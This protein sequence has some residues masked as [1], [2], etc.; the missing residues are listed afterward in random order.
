MNT[1][2]TFEIKFNKLLGP[3][4][5]VGNNFIGFLPVSNFSNSASS[6][7]MQALSQ[8]PASYLDPAVD[9]TVLAGY[10]AQFKI[11]TDE[12]ISPNSAFMEIIWND[13]AILPGL[14]RQFS[15]GSISINTTDPF[16]TPV[17]NPRVLSNPLDIILLTDG[18]KFTRDVLNTA[19]LSPLK[20]NET[21]PGLTVS[22]DQELEA[23]IRSTLTTLNHH[24]GT[25]S[26]LPR[27]L[28][29]VVDSELRVYGTIGLRIVDASIMPMLPAAHLQATVYAVAEKVSKSLDYCNSQLT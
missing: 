22:T 5:S 8:H 21:F 18:I 28:G 11:L 13:E 1:T 20:T 26:M 19:A 16:A 2:V 12:I 27:E 25:S 3:Y 29:G 14:Q 9:A 23:Y 10:T 4:T 7:H 24:V 17:I 15:R 6:I